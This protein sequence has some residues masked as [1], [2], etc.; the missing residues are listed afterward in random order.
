MLREYTQLLIR[1]LDEQTQRIDSS[2]FRLQ[3]THREQAGMAKR[4]V[5]D[6]IAECESLQD[7]LRVFKGVWWGHIA[8]FPQYDCYDEAPAHWAETW[9]FIRKYVSQS[10]KLNWSTEPACRASMREVLAAAEDWDIGSTLWSAEAWAAIVVF[11]NMTDK[12]QAE[13]MKK[14]KAYNAATFSEDF[15]PTPKMCDYTSY[16]KEKKGY[17]SEGMKRSREAV[18]QT[19]SSNRPKESALFSDK[20]QE[21]ALFSDQNPLGTPIWVATH[22]GNSDTS[23]GSARWTRAPSVA[24][25]ATRLDM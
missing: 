17:Q 4:A 15:I 7:Q 23:R 9:E 14:L 16:D 10:D 21:S 2:V 18:R 8:S 5:L 24:R 19:R 20:T 12:K 3:S 25:H 6:R 11:M 13:C 1:I 22:V